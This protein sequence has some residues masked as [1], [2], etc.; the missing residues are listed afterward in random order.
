MQQAPDFVKTLDRK[1]ALWRRFPEGDGAT[2]DRVDEEAGV[3]GALADG[4]ASEA[5]HVVLHGLHEERVEQ[6]GCRVLELL[7][8]GDARQE[9]RVQPGNMS[10]TSLMVELYTLSSYFQIISKQNILSVTCYLFKGLR[11]VYVR[12]TLWT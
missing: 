7:H 2:Y 9:P 4:E 11:E 8:V 10:S 6:R 5:R 12:F 3:V 1:I